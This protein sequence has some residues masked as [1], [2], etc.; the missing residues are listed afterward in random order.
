MNGLEWL[1]L[2]LAGI[3][4]VVVVTVLFGYVLYKSESWWP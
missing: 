4:V 1:R 3:G 2:I